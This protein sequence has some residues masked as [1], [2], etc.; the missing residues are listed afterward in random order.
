MRLRLIALPMAAAAMAAAPAVADD[1]ASTWIRVQSMP[2]GG[3]MAKGDNYYDGWIEIQG[4]DWEAPPRG[5]FKGEITGIEPSYDQSAA[6]VDGF[7]VKQKV[8]PGGSGANE[9]ITIGGARTESSGP[10]SRGRVKVRFPWLGCTEGQRLPSLEL[11]DARTLYVLE[12]VTVMD[13]SAGSATFAYTGL[14]RSSPS[15]LPR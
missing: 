8:K 13:C 7:T 12:G 11:R 15:S 2:L 3:S 9:T 4:W 10:Q 5:P 14:R 6:K 1:K